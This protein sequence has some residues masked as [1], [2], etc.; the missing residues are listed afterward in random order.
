MAFTNFWDRRN[1]DLR[2]PQFPLVALVFA[3]KESYLRFAEDEVGEMAKAMDAYY[4]LRTNR[5]T[6]FDLTGTQAARRPGDRRGSAAQINEIL[7]KPAS[8]WAV[9]TVIH[10]ATHQIGSNCGLQARYADIPLWIYEGMAMYFET[11]DLS[12]SKGWRNIGAVNRVRLRAF[13]EYLPHR[14]AD[15]LAS[16]LANSDRL[17]DANRAK[18]ALGEA[19]A[20]TYFLVKQRPKQYLEYIKLMSKKKPLLTDDPQTKIDEFKNVFGNL[21]QLDAEFVR[22]MGKVR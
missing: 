21:E 1:F 4:S 14:P 9:A 22:Q 13:R 5:I 12:S 18:D 16:L 17:R 2:E 8:E 20:L 6:M 7:S 19:W 11:P 3:S 10:E 15:S